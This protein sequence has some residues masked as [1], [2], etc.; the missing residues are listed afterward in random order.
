MLLLPRIVQP[1]INTRRI[2]LVVLFFSLFTLSPLANLAFGGTLTSPSP[3]L[4]AAPDP[5]PCQEPENRD[6][7]LT[8]NWMADDEKQ[9]PGNM[10]VIVTA[11]GPS[12]SA[13]TASKN[14]DFQVD[15][16]ELSALFGP[17]NSNYL[18]GKAQDKNH[19]EANIQAMGQADISKVNGAIQKGLPR[20]WLDAYRLK[21]VEYINTHPTLAESADK[22]A[23]SRGQDPKT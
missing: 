12:G 11:T 18:E 19:K 21:Y 1:V 15:F 9:P 7:M 2:I 3:T 8:D 5:K 23:D 14:V 4:A 17:T 22:F 6:D 13:V 16:S 10:Q 20:A